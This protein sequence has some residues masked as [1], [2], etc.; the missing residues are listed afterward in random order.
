MIKQ[1]TLGLVAAAA[2]VSLSTSAF[3]TITLNNGNAVY[4]STAATVSTVGSSDF[5]PNGPGGDLLGDRMTF[6]NWWWRIN[7]VSTRENA[8]LIG[9][10]AGSGTSV[11]TR[12]HTG[13]GAGATTFNSVLT[14]TLIDGAVPGDMTVLQTL[15]ITNTSAG[16]LDLSMFHILDADLSGSFGSDSAGAISGDVINITDTVTVGGGNQ[17]FRHTGNAH[18]FYGAGAF[19]AFQAQFTDLDIDNLT[20]IG[21]PFGPGDI[22]TGFQWNRVLA[23]GEVWSIVVNMESYTVPAPGALALLGMAGLVGTRRRRRA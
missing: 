3:A 16:T 4:I 9:V 18:N 8:F 20:N 1:S 14:M 13:L 2:V 17:G 15:T 22:Q 23:V 11:G 7:G 12:T 5:R 6:N 19:S 10:E 21:L